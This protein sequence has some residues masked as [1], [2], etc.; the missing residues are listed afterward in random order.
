[1][2]LVDPKGVRIGEA[3]L[4]A[5]NQGEGWTEY[6]WTNPLTGTLG[7]KRTYV[8]SVPRSDYVVYV[9]VYE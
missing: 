5:A 4:G 7:R 3:I 8:K 9:G 2:G 1:M 6:E